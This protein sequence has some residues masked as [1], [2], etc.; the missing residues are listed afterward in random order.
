[1]IQYQEK[2]RTGN[3]TSYLYQVSHGRLV[4]HATGRKPSQ[5]SKMEAAFLRLQKK[6]FCLCCVF[7][8]CGVTTLARRHPFDSY[9]EPGLEKAVRYIGENPV[10]LY[11]SI[12][13]LSPVVPGLAETYRPAHG[14]DISPVCDGCLVSNPTCIK[15]LLV[16]WEFCFWDQVVETIYNSE[17]SV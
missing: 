11:K 5:E 13:L 16:R 12:D 14:R 9:P 4:T 6:V 3:L 15:Y 7:V 17:P 2:I 10:I 8:F 1:M